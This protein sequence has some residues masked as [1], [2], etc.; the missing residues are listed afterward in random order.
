MKTTI[1]YKGG[2]KF[3][4][5]NRNHSTRIDL[6]EVSG[7]SDSGPT[8][9]ELFISSVGACIGVYVAGYCNNVGINTEGLKIDVD[10]EKETSVRPYHVKNIKIGINLPNA[11]VGSRKKALLK[12]AESC[13]IHQTI[14]AQPDISIELS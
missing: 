11:D 3:E 14:K 10:W 2:K 1:S 7:G 12:V 6:P 8:S 13:L 4:A 9:P 5:Q